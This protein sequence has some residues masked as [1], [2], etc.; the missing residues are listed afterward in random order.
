MLKI[1][2][3][4]FY[5]IGFKKVKESNVFVS[6]ERENTNYD[7]VQRLDISMKKSGYHLIQSYVKNTNS[8]GLNNAVG[9]TGYE[10]KLALRKMKE[11]GLKIKR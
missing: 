8:E 10:A 5:K 6:Y 11:M 3:K 9:L 4:K 2:D 1:A 7:Y